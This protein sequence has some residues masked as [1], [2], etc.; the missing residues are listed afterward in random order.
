MDSIFSEYYEAGFSHDT[1]R[2]IFLNYYVPWCE[3]NG[4]EL[5]I[6][7]EDFDILDIEDFE[8]DLINHILEHSELYG[9]DIH[10]ESEIEEPLY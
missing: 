4:K 7:Q 1:F 3:E 2:R 6:S 9:F 8:E 10:E 5:E